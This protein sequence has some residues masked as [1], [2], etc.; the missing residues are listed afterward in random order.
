MEFCIFKREK[1]KDDV[2]YHRSEDLFVQDRIAG[3]DLL[4]FIVN[5]QIFSP[6]V[7]FESNQTRQN[8]VR[9]PIGCCMSRDQES[10]R[11]RCSILLLIDHHQ[12]L[13]F[14]SSDANIFAG[15]QKEKGPGRPIVH[16]NFSMNNI[17]SIIADIVVVI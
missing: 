6:Q 17:Y 12:Y 15:F 11:Q 13:L 7:E 16:L 10:V 5:R 4:D 14:A 3:K 1:I 9:S 2:F 8:S